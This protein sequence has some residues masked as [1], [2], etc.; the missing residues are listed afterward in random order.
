MWKIVRKDKHNTQD[1]EESWIKP[2]PL[3]QPLEIEQ[4]LDTQIVRKTWKKRIFA[5]SGEVEELSY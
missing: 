1:E 4:I 3:A 5:I 2:M